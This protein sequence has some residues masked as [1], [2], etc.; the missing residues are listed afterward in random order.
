[1]VVWDGLVIKP[2]RKKFLQ[3]PSAIHH[4][5]L[6][7]QSSSALFLKSKSTLCLLAPQCSNLSLSVAAEKNPCHFPSSKCSCETPLPRNLPQ[8]LSSVTSQ[9]SPS[10][11]D[12][13]WLPYNKHLLSFIC[14]S[15]LHHHHFPFSILQSKIISFLGNQKWVGGSWVFWGFFVPIFSLQLVLW[16]WAG[17]NQLK[18]FQVFLL[19]L[20]F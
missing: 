7:L 10:S 12:H 11:S 8:L 4:P 19:T 13:N 6:L 16:S 14:S 20:F 18:E 15:T 2:H 17:T 5:L 3:N 1:M 9:P